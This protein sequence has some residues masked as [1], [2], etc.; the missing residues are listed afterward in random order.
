LNRKTYTRAA[1]L[2]VVLGTALLLS[3]CMEIS[4][5][6][7]SETKVAEKQVGEAREAVKKAHKEEEKEFKKEKQEEKAEDKSF[8]KMKRQLEADQA[9]A[10]ANPGQA[11]GTSREFVDKELLALNQR[12]HHLS[13]RLE[14][15]S[16]RVHKLADR[17]VILQGDIRQPPAEIGREVFAHTVCNPPFYA[18]G[19]TSAS[20][21]P[22]KAMAHGE[23]DTDLR[24]WIAFCLRRTV[25]G[26]TV[27]FIHRAERLDAILSGLRQGGG[28]LVVFPLW[29]KPGR[30]AKR[31]IVQAKVGG[32]GPTVLHP[33]LCLHHEDGRDTDE[34][35]AIL[36]GG[37]PLDLIR[38]FS[39]FVATP[40]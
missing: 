12:V 16:E 10:P 17:V 39:T 30:P 15:I 34:A 23:G 22:G 36:R 35:R 33:G 28:D 21:D 40:S 14:H 3:S 4:N 6:L 31:V 26:G 13:Q 7:S 20:P 32:K 29:P 38:A 19:S 9:R 24:D 37:E 18:A 2:S 8:A 1:A 25:P 5:P 11:N 27:T